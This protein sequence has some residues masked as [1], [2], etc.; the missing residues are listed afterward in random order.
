MNPLY[1]CVAI[2]ALATSLLLGAC[3]ALPAATPEP[4]LMTGGRGSPRG[5]EATATPVAEA[6]PVE[7]GV[8]PAEALRNTTSVPSGIY[9]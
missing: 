4:N 7:A 2:A 6:A 9:R 5:E 1:S 3:V 8:I